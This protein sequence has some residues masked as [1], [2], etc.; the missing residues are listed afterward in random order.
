ML[1]KMRNGSLRSR[2]G[3]VALA[4]FVALAIPVTASASTQ[5][6]TYINLANAISL[7]SGVTAFSLKFQQR[8]SSA[9][10][11]NGIN[12]AVAL[13]SKC[14]DCGAVA[15]AFQVVSVAQ[16]HLVTLNEN[17]TSYAASVACIRCSALAEAY[18]IMVVSDSQPPLTDEQKQGLAQVRAG[19]EALQNSGLDT[20]Q[21]QTQSDEL[22]N[23][24]MS[25]LES[26]VG[27]APVLSPAASGPAPLANISQPV[28]KLY[29]SVQKSGA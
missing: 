1:H 18:Q 21:I 8:Q 2:R 28:V 12:R 19:L 5:A 25:I 29:R 16:Q 27:P 10:T 4:V 17:T 14:H 7:R 15:I 20:D 11:V 26:S 13:A 3:V 22:V 6:V 24:A 9:S 23:Q